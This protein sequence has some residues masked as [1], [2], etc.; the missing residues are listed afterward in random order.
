MKGLE[1]YQEIAV[2]TQ[3]GGR[4]VVMLYDGAIKFLKRAVNELNAGNMA[5]KGL[6]INKA[7][8]IINELNNV[9]DMDAGGEIAAN[10]RTLYLFMARHLNSANIKKDPQ[11]IGDVISLLE[12]LNQGWKAIT[13]NSTLESEISRRSA[14]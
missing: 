9:L 14:E 1:T 6:Y 8:D 3:S 11:M 5:E 7:L 10:L 4:L 2:T 12:E 13:R